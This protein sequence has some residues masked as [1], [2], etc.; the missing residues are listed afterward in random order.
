MQM[1]A[2]AIAKATWVRGKCERGVGG[3]ARR[4]AYAYAYLKL[5]L[6]LGILTIPGSSTERDLSTHILFIH[7]WV[8]QQN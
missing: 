2:V 1:V 5:N 3:G 4:A 7:I 6:K 8:A